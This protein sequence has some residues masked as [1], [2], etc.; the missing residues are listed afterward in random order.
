METSNIRDQFNLYWKKISFIVLIIC[1][2]TGQS[3]AQVPNNQGWNLPNYDNRTLHYGFQLGINYSYFR[4]KHPQRF[5]EQDTVTALYSVGSPAFSL[6]FV[7]NARLGKYF[8]VRLLPTVSFYQR[9]LDYELKDRAP[10]SVIFS[11][12]FIEFPLLLKYKSTRRKNL[13]T[14][15]IGGIKPGLSVGSKKEDKEEIG[16]AAYDFSI[17]FG[18]GA[19]IYYPL[20]KF[21]PELRFSL[22]LMNLLGP[23][24]DPTIFN[25]NV[26]RLSSYT[27]T[28][29]FLFE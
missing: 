28:L 29:F 13:R 16:A 4:I 17:D 26:E 2:I 24:D 7:F 6:G 12:S 22:G 10:I 23:S 5:L 1:A 27:I 15:F 14:Y 19:D 9:R 8:D 21:S 18:F 11:S 20:F 3:Y 25:Q